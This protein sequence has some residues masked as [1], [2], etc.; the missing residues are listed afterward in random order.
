MALAAGDRLGPYEILA[1]LGTGGTGKVYKARDT[2]SGGEVAIQLLQGRLQTPAAALHH[3]HIC[4]LYDVEP[5]YLAMELIDGVPL[6]GPLSLQETLRFAA[7]ISDALD[8]AQRQGVA[9]GDLKPSNI[10]VTLHGIKLL[11]FGLAHKT[12]SDIYA[13]GCVLYEMLMGRRIAVDRR[14]VQPPALEQVLQRC[15]TEEP[16]QSFQTPGD[17]KRAL[18]GVSQAPGYRREYFVA[19]ASVAMLIVGLALLVMQFPFYQKFSEKDVLVLGDFSNTTGDAIF[20]GTLRTALEIQL[21]QSPFLQVMD[22][23]HM[24]QDLKQM[25][26]APDLRITNVIAHDICVR[27][28]QKAMINGAIADLGKAFAITVQAVDCQN[29]A[30]LAREQMQAEGRDQV[31]TAIAKAASGLRMKLGEPP[32][33]APKPDATASLEALQFYAL[34][35]AQRVQGNNLASIGFYRHALDLDPRFAFADLGA[36]RAW[37]TAG[38][39]AK[40]KQAYRD[41]FALSKGADPNLPV[42]AQAKKEF[43]ALK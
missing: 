39:S 43:A 17:L 29:G 37:A 31:P 24:Q 42:L 41:F 14:P 1:P 18:A 32:S 28:G 19:A 12:D 36:G 21:Q 15:L 7:E 35:E 30:T 9:H 6:K 40:A 27:E 10:L 4:E 20:D 16:S 23:Q 34:G 22:D 3:P 33:S 26:R 2:R 5:N 8:Y 25:G 11:N 38:D 13:F